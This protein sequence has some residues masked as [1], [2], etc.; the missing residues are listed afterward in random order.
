MHPNNGRHDYE[1]N[2]D[3]NWRSSVGLEDASAGGNMRCP[4]WLLEELKLAVGVL[5]MTSAVGKQQAS[6]VHRI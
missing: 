1:G 5:A 2:G 6:R 3:C 4:F